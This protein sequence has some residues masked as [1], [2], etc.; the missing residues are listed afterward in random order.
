MIRHITGR[1]QRG[2][3]IV[4][5]AGALLAL[6]ALVALAID[7]G[8]AY[9]QR[10]NAQNAVD[11]AVIAGVTKMNQYFLS[12]SHRFCD[13]STDPCTPK[14]RE[15]TAFESNQIKLVMVQALQAASINSNTIDTNTVTLSGTMNLRYLDADGKVYGNDARV[16]EGLGL[17]PFA[18][19][20]GTN[21]YGAAGLWAET[22]STAGTYFARI[23]GINSVTADAHAGIRMGSA[24]AIAPVPQPKNAGANLGQ[25]ILWPM[26][27]VTPTMVFTTQINTTLFSL[28][29]LNGVGIDQATRTS[30]WANLSYNAAATDG[31]DCRQNA[32]NINDFSCFL[33]RGFTPSDVTLFEGYADQGVNQPPGARVPDQHNIP[34]G[35]DGVPGDINATGIWIKGTSTQRPVPLPTIPNNY[36]DVQA[37]QQAGAFQWSVLIPVSDAVYT[38]NNGQ[39]YY[40]VVD[41]VAYKITSQHCCGGTASNNIYVND[42]KGNFL[43]YG[44]AAGRA[45]FSPR[46]DRAVR[47][48]QTVLQLGP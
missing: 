9:A 19:G 16:G 28:N 20:S 41:A 24:G 42:L 44:W 22:T 36:L 6:V 8:N 25:P 32:T 7:G 3:A 43:G 21:S 45:T 13:P 11:G 40:H 33:F 1:K 17:I 5:I 26:T 31:T 27:L 37:I 15:L 34:L 10:R 39:K 18:S 35:S 47:D 29:S 46:L 38:A 48:G 4:I 12:P 30:N 2:Q 14:V 23:I